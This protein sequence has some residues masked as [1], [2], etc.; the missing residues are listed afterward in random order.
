MLHDKLPKQI[1]PEQLC[2][3]ASLEVEH[4]KGS[5]LIGQLIN[6]HGD[7]KPKDAIIDVS[8]TFGVDEEG[9]CFVKGQITTNISRDCQ[10]CFQTMNQPITSDISVSPVKSDEEAARLPAHYEPLMI[11]NGQVDMA[12]WIA[13]ELYLALPL[14]SLHKT[15]CVSY[16][17]SEENQSSATGAG[18]PF[19]QLKNLKV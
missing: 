10:R 4:M 7:T 18:S 9:L 14:M 8:L 2:R 19:D 16:S 13:E 6:L 11:Q 12:E 3:T 5:I 17:T 1:S 15:E